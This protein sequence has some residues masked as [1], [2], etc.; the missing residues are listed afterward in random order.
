M[1]L[2]G[3]SPA[4]VG[5]VGP[6]AVTEQ[7]LFANGLVT[8]AGYACP[9]EGRCATPCVACRQARFTG[10]SVAAD[11]LIYE[12]YWA[13][14]TL[15]RAYDSEDASVGVRLTIGH[16]SRQGSGVELR[17]G[18]VRFDNLPFA[19][20]GAPDAIVPGSF[21]MF[22]LDVDFSQ[23]VWVGDSSIVVGVGPRA[24]TLTHQLGA[25]PEF[26]LRAGGVG[27]SAALHRPIWR[28]DRML[29]AVVGHGRASILGGDY[30]TDAD[31]WVADST[32]SIFE[33]GFGLEL[34]RA[35]GGGDFLG[36]LAF[37]PQW[38][39]GSALQPIYL[40]G[41]KLGLGYQW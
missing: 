23:R 11:T 18:G 24:A 38:W 39:E 15:T 1:M 40:D 14:G 12:P 31:E 41:L 34:R 20:I 32:L 36:R 13:W 37:E 8:P 7:Q 35:C 26:R 33:A 30:V 10:W 19:E 28:S 16:E 2:G 17:V 5:E 6:P 21:E 29:V 3:A 22:Q 25:D 9:S 4:T 27:L